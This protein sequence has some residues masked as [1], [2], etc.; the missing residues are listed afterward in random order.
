MEKHLFKFGASSLG[1]IMPKKWVEKNGLGTK[2]TIY[3]SEN[4]KGEMV[5]KT[6]Q[7]K[8]REAEEELTSENTRF[9]WRLIGSHYIY[10]TTRLRLYSKKGFSKKQLDM[11]EG[12]V[13]Q[14]IGFEIASRSRTDVV[15]EDLTDMREV[16]IKKIIS[17]LRYLV[18]EEFEE[19][20]NGNYDTIK[21][22]EGLVDR[23]YLLGV[24]YLNVVNPPDMY[25]HLRPIEF[26]ELISDT[27]N[28][29]AG[30]DLSG[31]TPL[32]KDIQKLFETSLRALSG[33]MK[34]IE[35]GLALTDS[36]MAAIGKYKKEPYKYTML[37]D[38]V[39]SIAAMAEIGFHQGKAKSG[40]L[41][42]DFSIP[43][44]KNARPLGKE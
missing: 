15:F 7:V 16:S 22:S 4:E 12:V 35:E 25:M 44:A 23:Y 32:F 5:V 34:A 18:T 17:R 27:L 24:R 10:G 6:S 29:L 39:L 1:L 13:K 43:E 3:L 38:F 28:R 26:L 42:L 8:E 31:M 36:L 11:I 40:E 19:L 37:H 30:M 33:D 2:S 21:N 14:Y 20:I 41:L 9:L